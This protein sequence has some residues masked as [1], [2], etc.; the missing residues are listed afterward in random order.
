MFTVYDGTFSDSASLSV[1]VLPIDDNP[2]LVYISSDGVFDYTEG[3]AS[4][5]LTGILLADEDAINSDVFVNSVTIEIVNG[6]DVEVLDISLV[7]PTITVRK[8]K[9]PHC[10]CENE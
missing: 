10:A 4:A 6:T 3:N 7:S 5:P 9:C 8:T 1:N 2:T